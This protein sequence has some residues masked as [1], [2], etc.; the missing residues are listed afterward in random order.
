MSLKAPWITYRPELKVLDC[1]VRDGGLVNNHMFED[2]L[3]KAVYETCIEAGIDY[4]EIGYK[5]SKRLF[6]RD[7]FGDW[8]YCDEQ[9]IRRIVGDNPSSLKL[10]AMAD[11]GKTDYHEDILPKDRSVLDVIRVACYVHQIPEAVNMIHDAHDKGYEVTCNL[12][13]VSKVQEN[14]LDQALEVIAETPASTIVV[15]D[16]NGALYAEQIEILVK[17]YLK[18][19]EGRDK[20]VGIHAHNN[21]QLAFANT[22]EAIIHGANRV[23][24]TM[25]GLGRGAGNCS[26]ELLLGFLRNPKFKLRPVLRLLEERFVKLREEIEWGPLV[27]YTITGQLNQHPRAAI[28]LRAGPDRDRYVDFYDKCISE[29]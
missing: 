23:D 9:D 25:A 26:T 1:T 11:A 12:M 18:A 8:K 15:V 24:C 13:A 10:A 28:A 16:S 20:Q 4:M 19:V 17:K 3:V 2:G 7:Q 27:P 14:E 29:I 22:I 6:A 5:A 21:Q